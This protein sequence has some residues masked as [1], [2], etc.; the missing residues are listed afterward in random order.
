MRGEEMR[1]KGRQQISHKDTEDTRTFSG[2][3]NRMI[4]CFNH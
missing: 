4:P 2:N 1:E 3:S